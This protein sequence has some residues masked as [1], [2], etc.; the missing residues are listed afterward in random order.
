MLFSWNKVIIIINSP[1]PKLGLRRPSSVVCRRPHS[2]NI[3]KHSQKP[4]GQSKSNF[5]WRFYGMG[6]S[7]LNIFH[8][9]KMAAMPIYGK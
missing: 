6:E 9:T 3:F 4:L 7:L 1:E 2:L 8:K 5:I